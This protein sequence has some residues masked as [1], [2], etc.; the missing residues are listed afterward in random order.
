MFINLKIRNFQ[1]H[2]RFTID[3][4][5]HVTTI[6]GPSDRGKSSI[7]R[8][9]RWLCTNQPAGNAHIKEGKKFSAVRLKVDDNVIIR[10]RSASKNTYSLNGEE[11]K[12]FGSDVPDSIAKLLNLGPVNFQQQHDSP[13]WLS[14]T[15]GQ[16]SRSLNAVVDLDVIDRALSTAA[17]NSTKAKAIVELAEEQHKEAKQ[18]RKSLKWVVKAKVDL[19]SLEEVEKEHTRLATRRGSLEPLVRETVSC[20]RTQKI[21][22]RAAVVASYVVLAGRKV[23]GAISRRRVLKGLIKQ[24]NNLGDIESP[25]TEKLDELCIMYQGVVNRRELLG[26]LAGDVIDLK[27]T[28]LR[29]RDRVKESEAELSRGMKGLCPL[30][31]SK[32]K[33]KGIGR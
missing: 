23:E 22:I 18:K 26:D 10:K 29:A 27:E 3:L 16:V 13:F 15:A 28:L 1:P 5:P 8:A 11:F 30:C 17:K 6:V 31:G 19:D 7:I 24:I 14:D 33:T 25:D 12:S 32:L 9:L 4:D 21:V 20:R 2:G